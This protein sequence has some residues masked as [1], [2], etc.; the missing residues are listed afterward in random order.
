MSE[1]VATETPERSGPRSM[2]EIQDELAQ[3][4]TGSDELPQEAVSYTHLRAH[5]T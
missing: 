1:L 4:L 5:E 3:V 2:G